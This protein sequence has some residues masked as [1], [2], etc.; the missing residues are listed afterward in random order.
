[1]NSEG[2]SG[3]VATAAVR[4]VSQPA[5]PADA[6]GL[7]KA[8]LAQREIAALTEPL[9]LV[10]RYQS[11]PTPLVR[12]KRANWRTGRLDLVLR[13]HFDIMGS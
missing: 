8:S 9:A 10:R 11:L 1:V 3:D 12:D 4:V 5:A 7:T 6:L 13:G 2:G